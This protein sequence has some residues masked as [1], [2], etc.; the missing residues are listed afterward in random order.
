MALT[1]TYLRNLDEKHRLA[2]PRKLRDQFDGD[3]V[4]SLYVCP[5]TQ[6]SLS[7]YTPGE[8][9][10]LAQRL[11]A[12]SSPG[13]EFQNYQRLL[14]ARSD[15]A[16]LD[17]QGRILIPEWLVQHAG[18]QK[19]VVLIGVH[20]RAEVWDRETWDEFMNTQAPGFDDLAFNTHSL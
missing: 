7:L 2:I 13:R 4:S 11:A 16:Q 18:L 3:T 15:C 6:K 5:G 8:F 19:D 20:N 12:Q 14:F 10:R 17:S 9:D 1:G